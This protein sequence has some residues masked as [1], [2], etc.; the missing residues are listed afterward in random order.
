MNDTQAARIV[1]G[2]FLVVFFHF[3]TGVRLIMN[4]TTPPSP[5]RQR[6][7]FYVTDAQNKFIAEEADKFGFDR[8]SLLRLRLFGKVKGLRLIRRPSYNT[9]LLGDA[10]GRLLGVT[11]AFNQN[12]YNLTRISERLNVDRRDL[13]GLDGAVRRFDELS[14]ELLKILNLMDAVIKGRPKAGRQNSNL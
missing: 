14:Q 1:S 8:S 4:A 12:G 5:G 13:F 3:F 10:M 9:R 2:G 6:I 7:V 11:G